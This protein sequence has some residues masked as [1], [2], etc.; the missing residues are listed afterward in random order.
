MYL[1][2]AP[3]WLNTELK[4]LVGHFKQ[5]RSTNVDPPP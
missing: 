3:Y 1:P 5:P 4:S 2:W